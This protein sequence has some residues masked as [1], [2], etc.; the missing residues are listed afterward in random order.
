SSVG[1]D[2]GGFGVG[3][4]HYKDEGE[5]AEKENPEGFEDRV[6]GN[7]AG[8]ALDEAED[9]GSGL[10]CGSC[11]VAASTG[12]HLLHHV[13]HVARA[14]AERVDVC[15][16]DVGVGLLEANFHRL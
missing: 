5:Q 7:H 2:G 16:E 4:A 15:A 1:G 12:H 10:M 3:A 14:G 6:V 9:H 11:C 8:F 13:H